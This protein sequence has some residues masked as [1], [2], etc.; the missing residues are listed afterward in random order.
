MKWLKGRGDE[1]MTF[2][3]PILFIGLIFCAFLNWYLFFT[4]DFN[5]IRS[6]ESFKGYVIATK[7]GKTNWAGKDG[8]MVDL[9]KNGSVKRI[10]TTQYDF[11]K[12][13]V[14]DTIK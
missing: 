14:G 12:Y 2:N 9:E 3:K 10:L 5:S 13:N 7:T 6:Y 11:D 4:P 1:K 8:Y